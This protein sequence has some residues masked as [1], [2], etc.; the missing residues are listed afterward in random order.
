MRLRSLAEAERHVESLMIRVEELERLVSDH[1][2]RLDTAQSHQWKRL[3][4][5]V[6]GWPLTDWNASR[7]QWRPWHR[8]R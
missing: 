4:F 7:R 8:E 3:W 6:Q 5:F 2:Q 1:A